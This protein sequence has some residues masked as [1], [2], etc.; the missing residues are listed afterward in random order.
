[1]AISYFR[2]VV[3][4]G[5]KKK[6]PNLKGSMMAVGG[7]KEEIAPLIAEL[8]KRDVRIA[9]FNSPTSLTI[10]GDEPAIDEL[11]A[12]LEEK[13]M[14]S[15]KLQVDVAYHSH[16]M[17]LAAKDYQESFSEA[18]TAM[19][20]P[21]KGHKTGVNMLIEIG[22][23]SAL[24]GPVKQ[25]LRTAGAN[26]A[27][28]PY[29]LSLVRKR[30]AVETALEL[31]ATLFVKGAM[32]NMG[33]INFPRQTKSPLLLVDM[34]RY[35]WNHATKYWH[36]SRMMQKHKNRTTPRNGILGTLANYS[37]DLEPTWRNVI[38]V[39]D[40]PWLRHHKIQSLVLFPMSAFVSMAVEAASQRANWK[41]VHFDKFELRDISVLSPL[42]IQ[43]DDV[44]ITLQLRS[45]QEGTLVSSET[46]DEFRIHSWA[47]NKGWT[48]H[49]KGLIC[50]KG[51]DSDE[52]DGT[53]LA[54]DS[55]A[56]LKSTISKIT[57][58]DTVLV[59]RTKMYDSLADL[60]VSYGPTF[61]GMVNC[62]ASDKGS[63][64][65]LTVADTTQEMPQGYQTCTV[66]HPAFLEQLI[67]MCWPILGAGRAPVET[68]YL[69]SSI[70]HMTIARNVT[71]LTNK[72][73]DALRAF[74]KGVAPTSHPKPMQVSMFAMVNEDSKE[75]TITLDNL[76]ISPIVERNESSDSDAHR[77]LC[78]KLDWEPFLQPTSSQVTPSATNGVHN[79]LNG[80]SNGVLVN[81]TIDSPVNRI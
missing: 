47:A 54:Q 16:H 6:F 12:K 43:D 52:V 4:V 68:V 31:A 56:M 63:M 65:D 36:E 23:H 2:G 33:A 49:C 72:P 74:C 58:S 11:Q 34:P 62:Q 14:L 1:M 73:G 18:L 55:E 44:E 79:G 37:N 71:E 30:G 8:K 21:F 38:R 78:Y 59:D 64:A 29:A 66:I 32:L 67:E 51:N 48:E 27:K 80:H 25:I 10:S 53:R 77:E 5:L 20:E 81:G 13:A 40:L 75:A 60:G 7:S 17:K 22:P 28:I 70:G 41:G 9:C 76:T 50:V 57:G 39:D 19:T 35:P 42:M 24:A 3:T 46:W 26:A 15:R 61:Q 45:Y 69:P